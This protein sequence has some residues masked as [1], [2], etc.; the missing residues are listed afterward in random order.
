M[1]EDERKSTVEYVDLMLEEK[2][3][4]L[5]P[6]ATSKE[7]DG[8]DFSKRFQINFFLRPLQCR[9]ES[10]FLIPHLT[11]DDVKADPSLE[12]AYTAI[13]N[14]WKETQDV[15]VVSEMGK[16]LTKKTVHLGTKR[17]IIIDVSVNCMEIFQLRDTITGK[18]IHGQEEESE[19]E[20]TH[21]VRF[22][23]ETTRGDHVGVRNLGSWQIIDIDDML[24]GN[25]WH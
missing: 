21:L 14:E 12:G 25:V 3:R 16:A 13:E 5:F 24:D 19:Q 8:E 2:I 22:E 6:I 15:K 1:T 23:M 17:S 20:V 9:L 18:I 7:V 11:R 10:A 4:K